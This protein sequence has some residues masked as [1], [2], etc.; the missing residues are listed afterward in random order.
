MYCNVARVC[1]QVS[2]SNATLGGGQ[3]AGS[4]LPVTQ[5]RLFGVWAL[6]IRG[7]VLLR[8]CANVFRVFLAFLLHANVHVC[9]CVRSIACA[10][11]RASKRACGAR[12]VC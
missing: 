4:R 8:V 9:V 7:A 11:V 5:S 1:Y 10:C 12:C 2:L 6:L 3:L